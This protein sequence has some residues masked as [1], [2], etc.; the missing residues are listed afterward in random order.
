MSLPI[1]TI[2]W[3]HNSKYPLLKSGLMNYITKLTPGAQHIIT[4]AAREIRS[5]KQLCNI[6]CLLPTS[7]L[8]SLVWMLKLHFLFPLDESSVA[9]LLQTLI[10]GHYRVP[11]G[12]TGGWGILIH[13]R[14]AKSETEKAGVLWNSHLFRRSSISFCHSRKRHFSLK[15]PSLVF[16][17]SGLPETV[18]TSL[19]QDSSPWQ[20]SFLR[21][22]QNSHAELEKGSI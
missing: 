15:E 16:S 12:I 4:D 13:H 11:F 10:T 14:S 8:I 22:L 7:L 19:L 21:W 18:Y 3:F 1:Q 17:K 5:W 9:S 20:T 2:L 6:C